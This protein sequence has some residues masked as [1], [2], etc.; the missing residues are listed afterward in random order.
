MGFFPSMG[1]LFQYHSINAPNWCIY[2]QCCII[3]AV[4]SII[5]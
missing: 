3:L 1:F 4:D 2:H 5:K